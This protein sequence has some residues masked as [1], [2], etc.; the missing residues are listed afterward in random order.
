MNAQTWIFTYCLLF[1][2]ECFISYY[3]GPWSKWLLTPYASDPTGPP[4]SLKTSFSRCPNFLN[5]AFFG[6]QPSKNKKIIIN[7]IIFEGSNLKNTLW[8]PQK[9]TF[10]KISE[11]QRILSYL[12][13]IIFSGGYRGI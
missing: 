10:L 3:G 8:P 11:L 13:K 4:K 5:M 9:P 6:L 2:L 1:L 7:D 12:I